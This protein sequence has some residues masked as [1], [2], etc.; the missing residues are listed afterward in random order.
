MRL[1]VLL[2]ATAVLYLWDITI[3]GMGNQFYAAAAQAGSRNWEALLFGS[4]D[5]HNFITVDK[6]PAQAGIDPVDQALLL[7]SCRSRSRL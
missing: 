6:P 1:A 2:A 4:L 7:R 5:S 3:N